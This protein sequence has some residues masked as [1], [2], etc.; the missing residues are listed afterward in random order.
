MG[1]PDLFQHL[2]PRQRESATSHA[3]PLLIIAGA[4]A[5][6]GTGKTNILAHCVA[7]LVLEGRHWG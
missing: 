5:G 4:G 7:H 3:H 1:A 6:T 2:N